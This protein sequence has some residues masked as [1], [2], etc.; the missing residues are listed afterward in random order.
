[1]TSGQIVLLLVGTLLV[2]I[3]GVWQYHRGWAQRAEA[4]ERARVER[5]EP[6][7]N[8][9]Q[10][11]L[12]RRLRRTTWGRRLDMWLT[13][14]GV[15][16]GP[17]VYLALCVLAFFGG[18]L[19]GIFVLGIVLCWVLG[20]GGVYACNRYIEAMRARRREAFVVQLPELTRVMSNASSAGLSLPRAIELGAEEVGEPSASI[21]HRVVEELRLGQSVEAALENLQDR[22]PSRE[23]KVLVSTLVIQ[24]R[25]G[26]D[27]V[28]ALRDMAG[29]LEAR[30]DLRR[31]V[32][33]IVAGPLA[34]GYM[35]GGLAVAFLL[36]INVA[37]PGAIAQMLSRT[38]GQIALAISVALFAL[39]FVAMRRIT[40][41]DT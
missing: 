27:T 32:R 3:L 12:D 29:T 9:L 13:S 39:A 22:L 5:G 6:S 11:A 28:R 10:A 30:K 24:Q 21:M 25:A 41:I 23:V 33:T 2:F 35:V 18:T 7:R 19:A 17:A 31:E 26:G 4:A 40:R 8:R 1:M 34:T 14:S 36:V 16:M 38:V 37:I 15:D 20:I